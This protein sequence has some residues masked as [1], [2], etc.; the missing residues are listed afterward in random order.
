METPD[1]DKMSDESDTLTYESDKRSDE[2]DR[3]SE[4]D[5]ILY[6]AQSSNFQTRS[7]L[8]P[9]GKLNKKRLDEINKLI[10]SSEDYNIIIDGEQVEIKNVVTVNYVHNSDYNHETQCGSLTLDPLDKEKT[11][12]TNV[13]T[14]YAEQDLCTD[15]KMYSDL[16]DEEWF[17]DSIC[18]FIG[19]FNHIRNYIKCMKITELGGK[20]INIV[21][22][23]LVLET[24][25]GDFEMPQFESVNDMLNVLY[26]IKK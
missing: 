5:Y 12:I 17:D 20:K 4:D 26:S 21:D 6:L 11:D 19:G 13:L 14:F 16:D 25:G 24:K 10:S 7:M 3:I 22:S 1:D 9:K 2:P 18:G 8:I 15:E 23:L